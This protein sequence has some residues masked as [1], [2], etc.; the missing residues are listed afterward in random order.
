MGGGIWLRM[1]P[2]ECRFCVVQWSGSVRGVLED[3]MGS[4]S[5]AESVTGSV[6]GSL[7]GSLRDSAGGSGV[8]SAAVEVESGS[9]LGV[10]GQG[11]FLAWRSRSA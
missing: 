10:E 7:S 9:E 5:G 1:L 11:W 6:K 2:L 4:W 3:G 8:R